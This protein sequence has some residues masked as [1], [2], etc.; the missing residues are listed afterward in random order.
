MLNFLRS[1]LF[2]RK[3]VLIIFFQNVKKD[4]NC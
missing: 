4:D 1:E 2:G 3:T